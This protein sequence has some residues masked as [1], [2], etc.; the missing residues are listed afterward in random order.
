MNGTEASK[1][2]AIDQTRV[3]VGE[4][5]EEFHLFTALLGDLGIS[6]VQVEHCNGK[7]G[8]GSYLKTLKTRTGFAL[9]QKVAIV[10]DADE[11]PAVAAA[12]V[13]GSISRAGFHESVSVSKLIV[14]SATATGALENLFL[15]TIVG[16][17]IATCIEEYLACATGA[18]G[19]KHASATNQ[20]KS[21]VHAWLAAQD[22]PDLRLG[23]AAEKGMLDWSSPTFDELKAFLRELA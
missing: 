18:T 20:A 8:L 4:G 17:P 23:I 14:P 7:D 22:P 10:R 16:Q 11:D 2:K 9:V 3:L 19:I 1:P 6:G 12:S 5:V 13:E 21:R 15:Q